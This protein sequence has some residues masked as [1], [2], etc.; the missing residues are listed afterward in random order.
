MVGDWP[1]LPR[2]VGKGLTAVP[3]LQLLVPVG[4]ANL[5]PGG[6]LQLVGGQMVLLEAGEF[7]LL[8]LVLRPELLDRS[9]A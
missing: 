5:L 4:R 8:L 7:R 2:P 6:G 9:R 1:L 3:V